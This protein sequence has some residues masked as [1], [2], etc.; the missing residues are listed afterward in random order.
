MSANDDNLGLKLNTFVDRNVQVRPKRDQIE[1][2]NPKCTVSVPEDETAKNRSDKNELRNSI[3]HEPSQSSSCN[4]DINKAQS[5]TIDVNVNVEQ[6]QPSN[7]L[8][9]HMK[10]SQLNVPKI[11]YPEKIVFCL[12]MSSDM[13]Q[14][15]FRLGDGSQ[16]TPLSMVKRTI[17]LFVENKHFINRKHEF[18]LM[19]L[20]ENA[21][22]VR[23]FTNDPK[24]LIESLQDLNET[25]D[26][27]TCDLASIVTLVTDKY[28]MRIPRKL[29]LLPYV[30]RVILIY[31]RSRCMIHF[32]N[33]EA[34]DFLINYPFFILDIIYIH[35][36]PT[37]E[38]KCQEIFEALCDL[39]EH[40]KSYIY[41][42]T[43]N[44]TKLHNSMAK[45]LTHPIQRCAQKDTSYSIKHPFSHDME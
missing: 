45:L 10:Q 31:G 9:S 23:E 5:K 41:E 30:F 28:E 29:S 14:V 24:E 7:S 36:P 8:N 42:V 26:C 2:F 33:E 12:D 20:Y 32:S 18:S 3:P 15:P 38:N 1:L 44:T 35:E 37:S 34:R 19:V 21:T 25:Q 39:D 40:D 17:E 22:W 4:N 16:H 13:E 6:N 43:R 27:A 11:N